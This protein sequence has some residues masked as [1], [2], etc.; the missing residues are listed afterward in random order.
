MIVLLLEK[1]VDFFFNIAYSWFSIY[2]IVLCF[3]LV[4]PSSVTQLL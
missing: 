3:V 4:C 2:Y 1:L